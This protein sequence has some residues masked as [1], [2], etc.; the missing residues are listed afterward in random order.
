MIHV[1]DMIMGAGKT[2]S[3]IT[4][5][6]EH[7]DKRYLYVT[8]FLDETERVVRSCSE[9]NFIM[10]SNHI[11]EYGYAKHNHLRSLAHQRRNVAM[12]HALFLMIDDITA[13]AIVDSG[14]TIIIDE[15]VDVFEEV[16][17]SVQDIQML[18]DSGYLERFG[19]SSNFEYFK[20]GEQADH[21]NGVFNKFF[22]KA[23]NG[24]IV[25]TNGWKDGH[26]VKYGFWQVNRNLFTL[27][28]EI[29]IL[30]YLFDGMPMKGFLE[31]SKLPYD[32]LGTRKCDDGKYRFCEHGV[33]PPYV[34]H[35]REMVHVCD[36]ESIN[37]IGDAPSALSSSWTDAA[38]E[39]GNLAVLERHIHTF[40]RRHVPADIGSDKQM[41]SVFLAAKDRISSKT[42]SKKNFVVFNSKA[43]N[44][45][46]DRAALA[47]CVNVYHNPSLPT[48]LRHVG[49]RLSWSK[50]AVAVMVQWVWRSRIRNGQEI[51]LY[52]PS[53]RMRNL[54]LKW[55]KDAEA[56]YKKQQEVMCSGRTDP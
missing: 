47:Y 46:G 51:W 20:P 29:F 21:Y 45:Y 27:S 28:D 31:V 16:S 19:G 6:N 53:R 12:T 1:V 30:T 17:A 54:F 55:M 42:A 32:Y 9:L 44:I 8:P 49:V 56:A 22:D 38:V 18:V 33:M 43:T 35:L 26:P 2:E 10:P 40:F 7:P 11:P 36:R 41:W 48:Y 52:L 37:R 50:Y 24:Q 3:A 15:V 13:R 4:Y 23:R 34:G 25:Q 39:N 5:M 14:Y